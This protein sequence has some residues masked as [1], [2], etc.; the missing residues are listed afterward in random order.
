M[1][2]ESEEEEEEEEEDVPADPDCLDGS[3]NWLDVNSGLGESEL[4]VIV[5]PTL[6][7]LRLMSR[8]ASCFIRSIK[9]FLKLFSSFC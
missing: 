6:I 9:S 5:A 1:A 4:V 2:A 8:F 7:C 3:I